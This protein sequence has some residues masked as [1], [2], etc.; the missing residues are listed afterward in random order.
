MAGLG[1]F[2]ACGALSQRNSDPTRASRP[3]DMVLQSNF[4][5]SL[6]FQVSINC[7]RKF[8]FL[9]HKLDFLMYFEIISISVIMWTIKHGLQRCFSKNE[10]LEYVHVQ[11][12]VTSYTCK[13]FTLNRKRKE[14]I[15]ELWVM[16]AITLLF[17]FWNFL[18]VSSLGTIF[19]VLLLK[20]PCYCLLKLHLFSWWSRTVMD[21]WLGKDPASYF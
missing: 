2:S 3:W 17:P 18:L 4:S 19:F 20:D 12:V 8:C 6:L 15:F 16:F 1:G 21:L 11:F 10:F 7:W 9:M 5:I 13:Y 14:T